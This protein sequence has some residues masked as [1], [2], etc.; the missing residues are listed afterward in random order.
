HTPLSLHDALPIFTMTM[1]TPES[2]I[3]VTPSIT[4]R[5]G[6]LYV[7]GAIGAR[8]LNVKVP[9]CPGGTVLSTVVARRFAESHPLFI[10][11]F[12]KTSESPLRPRF[13]CWPATPFCQVAV[14]VFW[15]FTVSEVDAPGASVGQALSLWNAAWNVGVGVGGTLEPPDPPAVVKSHSLVVI[16]L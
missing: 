15:N 7:P 12:A 1:N 2:S 10:P 6:R 14:P 11:R 13:A 9:V 4:G 3:H 16:T 8:T 5:S